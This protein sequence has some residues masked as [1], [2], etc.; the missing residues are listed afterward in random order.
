MTNSNHIIE[1]IERVDLKD[2]NAIE[3]LE[4]IL[5]TNLN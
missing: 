5:T 2:E 4:N 3:L 1:K